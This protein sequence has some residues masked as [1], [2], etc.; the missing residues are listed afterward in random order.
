MIIINDTVS[1]LNFFNNKWC[2]WFLSGKK[3]LFPLLNL[4]KNNLNIS[5]PGTNNKIKISSTEI[6]NQREQLRQKD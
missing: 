2:K 3:G 1:W 4:D 5:R 6:R